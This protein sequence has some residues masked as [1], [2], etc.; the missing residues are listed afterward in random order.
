MD[1]DILTTWNK[2]ERACTYPE[3]VIYKM[4]EMGAGLPDIPKDQ[5]L[6]HFT[7]NFISWYAGLKETVAVSQ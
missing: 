1:K 4:F 3:A 2:R 7:D 6:I 5:L